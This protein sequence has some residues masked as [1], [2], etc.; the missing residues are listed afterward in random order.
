MLREDWDKLIEQLG[1]LPGGADAALPDFF[2]TSV[3]EG[4]APVTSEWDY[5]SWLLRDGNILSLRFNDT[6]D[7]MQLVH[8]GREDELRIA[9]AGKAL[10]EAARTAGV[11]PL[12][13]LLL[14]IAA[15]QVDDGKRL[16]VA[17]PRIDG[18]AKDLMLMTVCRLCG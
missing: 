10:L 5:E 9:R 13:L 15:G 4:L 16:K 7:G 8:V 2:A 17:A 18:A 12:L 6:V 11:S 3:D 1:S 14:A